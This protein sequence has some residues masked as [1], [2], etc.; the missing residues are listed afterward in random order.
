MNF[1]K[2]ENDKL[3][4]KYSENLP[5]NEIV[6][7]DILEIVKNNSTQIVI[8]K[9]I[10]NSYYVFLNDKIYISDNKINSNLYT[11]IVLVAHE[12]IHSVQSKVLQVLNYVFS[13]LEILLFIIFLIM[14]LVSKSSNIIFLA[15]YLIVTT[16]S[17]IFRSILEIDAVK[18]SLPLAFKYLS[19]KENENVAKIIISCTQQYIKKYFLF[20]IIS[21]HIAKIVRAILLVLLYEYL[22]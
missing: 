21:L 10:K 16:I 2:S 15:S 18:K 8:D 14:S 1:L 12:C 11:R 6:C 7:K 20:F 5:S 4:Q 9:E 17:I 22:Y 13:N 3:A 19:N